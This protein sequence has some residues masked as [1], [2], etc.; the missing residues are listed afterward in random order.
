MSG[1]KLQG[2]FAPVTWQHPPPVY[3]HRNNHTQ[4]RSA[5][6]Q[7]MKT[8]QKPPIINLLSRPLL[9]IN[10][11]TCSV[12]E[13]RV[14]WLSHYVF[15]TKPCTMLLY[16]HSSLELNGG[17]AAQGHAASSQCYP[18]RLP[19]TV[20]GSRRTGSAVG[21][22][23]QPWRRGPP[24]WNMPDSRR[25]SIVWNK[26]PVLQWHSADADCSQGG[27][28]PRTFCRPDYSTYQRHTRGFFLHH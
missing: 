3:S 4:Q 11:P 23:M 25:C 2:R 27:N 14:H 18:A 13:L 10:M 28:A 7:L 22:V 12:W 24:P 21:A 5:A 26:H 20:A 17:R 8:L 15:H 6:A 19:G 1:N 16:I 9:Y